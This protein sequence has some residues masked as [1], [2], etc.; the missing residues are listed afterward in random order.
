[1][2]KNI[3][4]VL[5]TY[6]RYNILID[7]IAVVLKQTTLPRYI[8]L[9]DNYSTD[10]TFEKLKKSSDSRME[11][12][13]MD[14]NMGYGAAASYGMRHAMAKYADID[15]FW[16]LDDDSRPSGEILQQMLDAFDLI[17]P[18]HHLGVLGLVGFNLK[19]GGYNQIGNNIENRDRILNRMPEVV[20]ADFVLMDGSLI[21]MEVV[22]KC[23]FY[24]DDFFMMAEDYEYCKRV[25]KY[26]FKIGLLQPAQPAIERLALGAGNRF[27]RS[28]VW[29]G[30]YQA[31]NHVHILRSYFSMKDCFGFIFRQS[32]FLIYSLLAPD[33]FERIYYR[34]LGIIHGLRGIRGRTIEPFK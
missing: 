3:C 18:H 33:R 23:G 26:N 1:M 22:D 25:L 5:V 14:S 29:R 17:S 34:L 24:R 4:L 2:K 6:N 9:V 20:Q 19:F 12:I 32:K 15:F 21:K 10:G 27:S 8:I 16:I 28:S 7:T 13:Q 30:Y 31:R 11:V